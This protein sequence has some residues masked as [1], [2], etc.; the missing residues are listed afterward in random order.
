MLD[1]SIL[2]QYNVLNKQ[3][4]RGENLSEREKE[5]IEKFKATI[6]EMTEFEQG[7][8]LGKAEGLVEAKKNKELKTEQPQSV[9]N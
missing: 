5:I 7:Y 6:P 1:K 2:W 8:L 9:K 3:K 4:E